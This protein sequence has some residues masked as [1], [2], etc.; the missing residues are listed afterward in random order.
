MYLNLAADAFDLAEYIV[1]SL[2]PFQWDLHLLAAIFHPQASQVLH[3]LYSWSSKCI[4]MKENPEKERMR[5]Q[6]QR[7][8]I[9][10]FGEGEGVT[11]GPV[12]SGISNGKS[13]GKKQEATYA[14]V[15]PMYFFANL[16]LIS[17][18]IRGGPP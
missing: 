17:R 9:N 16:Y 12:S 5:A 13:C 6:H 7:R 15:T 8:I 1:F 4:I 11:D 18:R 3:G 10:N 14:C 2:V